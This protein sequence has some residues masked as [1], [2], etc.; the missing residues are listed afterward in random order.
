MFGKG[1]AVAVRHEGKTATGPCVGRAIDAKTRDMIR[2]RWRSLSHIVVVAATCVQSAIDSHC[3]QATPCSC[4]P[5]SSAKL[6][7]SFWRA[8]LIDCKLQLN[9]FDRECSDCPL[10]RPARVNRGRLLQRAS[11]LLNLFAAYFLCAI[12]L[13]RDG[14]PAAMAHRFVVPD[15]SP[16]SNAPSTPDRRSQRGYGMSYLD[17]QPSTTPAGPPPPSS[18]ASFTPAGAPSDSFLGSSMMRGV[19][20]SNFGSSGPST[21]RTL[22]ERSDASNAPL[23]RS[24]RGRERGPSGLSRQFNF[25]EDAEGEEEM[26]AEGEDEL[27]PPRGSLFRMSRKDAFKDA[28]VDADADADGDDM[29]AEIE[30]FLVQEM[31][32]GQAANADHTLD[33]NGSDP[34]D[35]F[36]NMRHDDRPYGQPI[37]GEGSDLMMLNTPAATDRVRKEAEDIY[38]RSSAHFGTTTRNKEF[39]F[40]TIA[41]DIY[42]SQDAATLTEPTELLLS[43][44]DLVCRL[45]NDGVGAEED[46]DKMDNSLATISYRLIRLWDDYVDTLPQPDGEDFASIG[47]GAQAQPFEKAAFVAHLILRMHHTRFDPDTEQEKTPP[48]PEVLF[49]WM[50]ASHNLFPDQVREISRYKPSP[51]CHSLFWQTLRNALLRGNVTGASHMLKNAGWEHVRK[52]TRGEKAYTGKALE[53]VRRFS[54]A[55]W[56]ILD[57]CPAAADD[58]DIWNSSWTLFRVR[59]KGALD[60]LTLFAEGR[61]VQMDDFD[62][63]YDSPAQSMST[64]AKEASSQLPWDIYEHLQMVYGIVLGDHEAIL[65][66]AQDWCE[67]TVGLFGWWDDNTQQRR[68][69]R[70]SQGRFNASTTNR[71]GASDDYLD[72]LSAAFHKVIQSDLNPNTMDPVEVAI[73]SAFE[74][75]VTAVIGCLRIWSLP[76]SCSVAEIASLGEWLPATQFSNDLPAD[77]LDMEDLALLGISQPSDDEK[78]GIKD[79]TLVL[80]AREL[81][82][83]EHLSPQ[84]DGWEMAIQVLGRM[85][86]PEKS[87]QT[88]GELLRDLL[89]TLDQNSGSTVDKMWR[90]LNDLGMINF[91]EETAEVSRWK[92]I[93]LMRLLTV[94]QTFADILAKESHRYGEALWYFALSHKTDRVREVLNLLTSYSLVH[95][96]VYPAEKELDADLKNLLRNRTETL[97]SRAKQDLEAA[98]LLGRMLSGYA[99]LRKFYELRDSYAEEDPASSKAVSLRKQAAFALVAVIS[100]SDD[101]I[102][103]GLY[104]DTR[105]AVVSE[106]FLLA[107]LGEATVFL[108]QKPSTVSLEQIDV[109]LKAIEDL[110]TVGS[111]VYHACDEFFSLVLASGQGLKGSTPADLMR[112][113]TN[114][115]GASSYV[116]TGSSILAGQLHKSVAGTGT[117]HR[118][119]DWRKQWHASTRSEEVLRTLRLGLAQDLAALWL[120]DADSVVAF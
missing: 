110:Q 43:N 57:Q 120:E 113:S 109:L 59:A 98:Q 13:P 18:A 8:T 5:T 45:Y 33:D 28:N 100:S 112:K 119:W 2:Q 15:S 96:T 67:A 97:E 21:G 117:I 65:E 47:P 17:N 62:D 83:I 86:L 80:Y 94:S 10:T 104:D 71:F 93:F 79:T 3:L 103:G 77:G 6:F 61:D 42:T 30:R 23:G 82:G 92:M 49:S 51:A 29:E 25:D 48:L 76:V 12:A 34:G 60:R 41:R 37:I 88:V 107:L 11:P 106:D 72:R 56:E 66:T 38:R 75:N 108:G 114:A 68:S 7:R 31:E 16:A 1:Q 14:Q 105:D 90:I 46:V 85:D 24:I 20:K 69:L 70:I 19:G 89:A 22:F 39:R 40:G 73:A 116:M 78:Q 84:R 111:R 102:R 27:P 99:T 63:G 36:L 58:W 26:D 32:M 35:L 4:W 55:T 95:S 87:E 53:N 115:L 91:A 74:G 81:A 52:G 54:A 44:E 101:N 9:F 50:N 64:M 118:G